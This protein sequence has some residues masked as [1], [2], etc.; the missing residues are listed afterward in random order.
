ML[1][2]SGITRAMAEYYYDF[3]SRSE[4]TRETKKRKDAFCM[5]KNTVNHFLQSCSEFSKFLTSSENLLY[6]IKYFC[7]FIFLQ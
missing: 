6:K 5:T 7:G 4:I 1:S 3:L 2:L